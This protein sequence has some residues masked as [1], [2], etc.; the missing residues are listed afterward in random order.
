[1][2]DFRLN[3]IPPPP[4]PP[5]SRRPAFRPYFSGVRVAISLP[6]SHIQMSASAIPESHVVLLSYDAWGHIRPLCALAAKLPQTKPTYVTFVVPQGC[7]SRV[8]AEVF[9]NFNSEDAQIRSW[10]R[11]VS[12]QTGADAQSLD[13][14]TTFNQKFHDIYKQLLNG[15]PLTCA[16]TGKTFDSVRTPDSLIYDIICGPAVQ[17]AVKVDETSSV[18][19]LAWFSGQLAS[20]YHLFSPEFRGGE[21][22]LRLRVMEEVQRTGRPYGEVADEI[23]FD[24][25]TDRV[26]TVPGLP[27]VYEY[28]FSPQEMFMKGVVGSVILTIYSAY[29]ICHGLV[30]STAEAYEAEAIKAT[31]AWFNNLGKEVYVV[32]P[33]FQTGTNSIKGEYQQSPLATEIAEF[34][35]RT[36]ELQGPSSLLYFSLGSTFWPT[37]P[38]TVWAVVDVLIE[39]NIPFIM[40]VASP[41][42]SIPDEVHAKVK[43]YG[44][45]LVSP[46]SP[47]QAILAHPATGWF[48][49]HCGQNSTMEAIC[50]GVPVIC[51]PFAGDQPLNAIRLS[52]VLNVGYELLEVRTGRLGLKPLYR[53]G[54]APRGTVEAVREEARSVLDNAFGEDGRVKRVN[55]EKL[56][57]SALSA[58]KE[59]GPAKK[60]M[61]RLVSVLGDRA[62][63]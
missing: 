10:I 49:T 5:Q 47:Q 33:L 13:R 18:K 59:G 42:A 28:E 26:V 54:K 32:G 25:Y 34:L 45:G 17:A 51:W 11:I 31:R 20:N 6:Y 30:L 48:I 27:P 58:W 62:Q 43:A 40:S 39:R 61:E 63:L 52:V 36:L 46:W 38:E 21:G 2:A 60:E 57:D 41:F 19:L 7:V 53:T 56:R 29:E 3:Y 4:P 8:E 12:L 50:A 37:K 16:D 23:I 14:M 55:M 15:L 24:S 9:R 44:K 35:D 22:D 1:M